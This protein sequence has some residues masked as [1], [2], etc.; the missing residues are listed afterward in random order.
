MA[1]QLRVRR[2]GYAADA[3]ERGLEENG[4]RELRWKAR[5]KRVPVWTPKGKHAL[6]KAAVVST[7]PQN[8]RRD[9]GLRRDAGA[10]SNG[11]GPTVA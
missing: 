3:A 2:G 5:K 6:W 1:T 11:I 4:H 10:T 7:I 8:F 9:A